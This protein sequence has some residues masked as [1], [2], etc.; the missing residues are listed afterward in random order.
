MELITRF[1][2]ER[3]SPYIFMLPWA[4]LTLTFFTYPFINS[5]IMAFEQTNGLHSAVYVGF[6]NFTF[7]LSDPVFHK[8]FM[9]TFIIVCASIFI[10]I[11]LS[12]GLALL[13][14]NP[15]VRWRNT[16]RL[17]ILS[18]M[19]IGT[20]FVGLM[21]ILLFAPQYGLVNIIIQ[22]ALGWGLDKNW[23]QD[24][25]LSMPAIIIT[26]IWLGTGYGMV[27]FLAALQ[28]VDKSLEEAARIDGANSVQIFMNVTLPAIKPVVV[29]MV[30]MGTIASFQAFELMYGLFGGYGADNSA[31]T[32]IGYLY[33]TAF[34]E[35]DLGTGSAVGWILAIVIMVVSVIQLKITNGKEA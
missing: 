34:E 1:L 15:K 25:A 11:P 27:F 2:N 3:K 16:F 23:L 5:I 18:P 10:Q 32:I 21:F 30:I 9:N 4:L 19:L 26:S 24:P 33:R 14:N 7:V 35:G 28:M 12:L 13:L 6:D 17:L 22:E 20:M 29:F 8:A 31:L